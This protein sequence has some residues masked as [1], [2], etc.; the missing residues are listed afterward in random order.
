MSSTKLKMIIIMNIRIQVMVSERKNHIRMSGM[1]PRN[2]NDLN[3]I[4]NIITEKYIQ[5]K[6]NNLKASHILVGHF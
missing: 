3:H 1:M 6:E 5:L 2:K 4:T